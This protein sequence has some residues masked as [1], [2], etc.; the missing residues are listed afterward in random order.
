M[1]GRQGMNMEQIDKQSLSH[2]SQP[3]R[4]NSNCFA[5]VE[6]G[7]KNQAFD[8]TYIT[9]WSMQYYDETQDSCWMFATDDITQKMIVV[10]TIPPGECGKAIDAILST[11]ADGKK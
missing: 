2:T 11:K 1:A 6:K 8:I 4:V 10:N 3:K 5:D 9:A 7:I